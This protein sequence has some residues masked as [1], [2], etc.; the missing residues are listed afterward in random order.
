MDGWR[1]RTATSGQ[2]GDSCRTWPQSLAIGARLGRDRGQRATS[3]LRVYQDR[4]ELTGLC[5]HPSKN[6]EGEGDPR[7]AIQGPG[8]NRR[9]TK[10]RSAAC[11]RS[12][13]GKQIH[14]ASEGRR[15]ATN[16]DLP[17]TGCPTTSSCRRGE[18]G[19]CRVG[20]GGH[21]YNC[22][23]RPFRGST[24][25]AV[26]SYFLSSPLSPLGSLSS[27]ILLTEPSSMTE[28][29]HPLGTS[30]RPSLKLAN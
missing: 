18:A 13:F 5:V 1:V 25:D 26:V 15:L 11:K 9:G 4:A 3:E 16:N 6:R 8:I 24:A 27:S 21:V 29:S 20:G 2:V 14:C 7:S 12:G 19:T 17:I 22:Q 28:Q 23:Y 30:V 10:P